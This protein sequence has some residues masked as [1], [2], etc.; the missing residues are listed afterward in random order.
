MFTLNLLDCT[1]NNDPASCH[2]NSSGL[3]F[4]ATLKK[5][6]VLSNFL[7]MNNVP[8]ID[9]NNNGAMLDLNTLLKHVSSVITNSFS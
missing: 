2:L 3:N 6:V 5:I 9:L 4:A 1:N 8:S 7:L